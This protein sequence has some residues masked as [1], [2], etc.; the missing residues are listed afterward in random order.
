MPAGV[1]IS[2]REALARL[3]SNPGLR[4]SRR[5]L[6]AYRVQAG[7]V[8]TQHVQQQGAV[9]VQ[10]QH[11]S[12]EE[13]H[14]CMAARPR[15]HDISRLQGGAG[16]CFALQPLEASSICTSPCYRDDARRCRCAL[17]PGHR[18]AQSRTRQHPVRIGDPV[19][20]L[21]PRHEGEIQQVPFGEIPQGI[22]GL[23]DVFP[24]FGAAGG[25]MQPE[26]TPGEHEQSEPAEAGPRRDRRPPRPASWRPGVRGEGTNRSGIHWERLSGCLGL[27]PDC[28][29]ALTGS[30]TSSF[31]ER[32]NTTTNPAAIEQEPE[33]LRR[34]SSNQGTQKLSK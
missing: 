10:A 31:L 1:S 32:A 3:R 24:F 22:A 12:V 7:G 18:E 11:R 5:Q 28:D 29:D 8:S 33:V 6:H 2:K 19:Q 25:R 27:S 17:H 13:R 23:N 26:Q 20:L 14:R 34:L 9:R 21:Q 30:V 15:A 16:N 4:A